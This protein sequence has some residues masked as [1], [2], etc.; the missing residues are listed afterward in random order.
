MLHSVSTMK[1]MHWK[2]GLFLME[3]GAFFFYKLC[4]VLDLLR[5]TIDVNKE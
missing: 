4:K 2:M 1:K 5:M 3:N